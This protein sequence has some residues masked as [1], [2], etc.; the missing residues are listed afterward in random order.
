MRKLSFLFCLVLFLSATTLFAEIVTDGTLG[1][2][3]TLTGPDYSVNSS[4]GMQAGTNLYFSFSDLNVNT[5]ESVTFSGPAEIANIF[6]RVTGGN[7]STIDG[8]FRATVAGANIF[9]MNPSGILYGPNGTLD[10]SRGFYTLTS[11]YIGFDNSDRFYSDLLESSVLTATAPLNAGF[12]SSN[13]S[14]ITVDGTNLTGASGGKIA[15]IG[16]DLEIK[17]GSELN[18]SEG[19]MFLISL[20]S[21]GEVNFIADSGITGFSSYGKIDLNDS[22]VKAV[23]DK[24][25]QIYLKGS[26]VNLHN[27][28]LKS[29]NIGGQEGNPLLI[30]TT[31]L[32]AD[33]GSEMSST[34]TAGRAG[35]I[36]IDADTFQLNS[37]S[38]LRSYADTDGS[39]GGVTIASDTLIMDSS[40]VEIE[41]ESSDSEKIEISANTMIFISGESLI[42]NATNNN[43]NT[44]DLKIASGTIELIGNSSIESSVQNGQGGT[45]EIT[46][47]DMMLTSSDINSTT[48]GTGTAG[49]ISLVLNTSL[50]TTG[51]SLSFNEYSSILSGVSTE[52]AGNSGKIHIE[53]RFLYVEKFSGIKTENSGG[54]GDEIFL[55]I[56]EEAYIHK[57]GVV[58]AIT[59]GSG[60]GA[61]IRVKTGTLKIDYLESEHFTGIKTVSESALANSGTSG[62]IYISAGMM[63]LTKGKIATTTNGGGD[64]GSIIIGNSEK[65]M[66][67]ANGEIVVKEGVPDHLCSQILEM[68]YANS[69]HSL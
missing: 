3:Q 63:D 19:D 64:A 55:N 38:I 5:G 20:A 1:S 35:D 17:N 54:L 40:T 28:S 56:S 34:A 57:G 37:N 44:G 42:R 23:G 47:D 68:S 53:A 25:G 11:D 18:S 65:L 33:N 58:E 6:I 4:F 30:E 52:M 69:L 10:V 59:T 2:G 45:V 43:F 29:E 12:L 41:S 22:V 39:P 7:A 67:K 61:D 26:E 14:G 49:N 32:T 62:N 66:L 46:A 8:L 16:G 13:I 24:A 21:P 48:I 31:Y 9:F 27:S 60:K 50:T 15:F 36:L 51:D